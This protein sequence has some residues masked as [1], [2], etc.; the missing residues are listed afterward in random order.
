VPGGAG[1]VAAVRAAA[2]AERRALSGLAPPASRARPRRVP[3]GRP[4]TPEPLPAQ[5]A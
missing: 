1:D 4:L 2:G 3:S 5:R